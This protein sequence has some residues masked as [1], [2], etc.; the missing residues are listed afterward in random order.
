MEAH[1][2]DDQSAAQPEFVLRGAQG[3]DLAFVADSWRRNYLGD[4][5]LTPGDQERRCWQGAAIDVCL[6]SSQV[7][8]ACPPERHQQIL[9]W[10]CAAEGNVVH[11]V[12]VKP[13]YRRH[14]IARALLGLV[15]RTGTKDI[16]VSHRWVRP[17]AEGIGAIVADWQ[18]AG[19]RM[20]YNP[21]LIFGTKT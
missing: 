6:R 17:H 20:H 7:V 2:R 8:I 4:D 5:K 12:Y 10:V 9:G 1:P 16:H 15:L 3:D 18:R 14:G 21:A 19:G 13:Y 11:Y